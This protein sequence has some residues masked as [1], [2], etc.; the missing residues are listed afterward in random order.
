MKLTYNEFDVYC[1]WVR[2]DNMLN[3][4]RLDSVF[5]PT[6]PVC[7]VLLAVVGGGLESLWAGA[8]FL[9]MAL[10]ICVLFLVTARSRSR[11]AQRD[12]FGW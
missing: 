7:Y 8:I 5:S 10:V 11:S 1:D 12:L 6:L 2:W 3:S 4:A 9:A